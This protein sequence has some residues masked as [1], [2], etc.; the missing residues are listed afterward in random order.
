MPSSGGLLSVKRKAGDGDGDGGD[1]G[2]GEKTPKGKDGKKD[3]KHGKSPKSH[4]K[5]SSIKKS[6]K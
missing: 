5:S 1:F 6:R 2:S 4:G 3:R